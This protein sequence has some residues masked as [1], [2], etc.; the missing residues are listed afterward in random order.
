MPVPI[1]SCSECVYV[2]TEGHFTEV[3]GDAYC[4]L[5]G[6]VAKPNGEQ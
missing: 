5:C 2:S 6:A 3:E 4:P 1:L